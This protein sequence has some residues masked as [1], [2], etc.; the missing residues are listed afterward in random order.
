M[1]AAHA[2]H[3]VTPVTVSYAIQLQPPPPN[4]GMLLITNVAGTTLANDAFWAEQCQKIPSNTMY[5][6]LVMGAVR[7]FFKPT[8]AETS[9]CE[10]L[11][12]N[13]KHQW[14]A[15]DV[16]WVDINFNG[17]FKDGANGG[18]L[19]NWPKEEGNDGDERMYVR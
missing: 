1:C 18:S 4:T 16:D 10:M 2:L 17:D 11:Q 15:G 3:D 13:N 14:S 8:N 19:A 6:V 9:Y 12:S 7:D 5:L